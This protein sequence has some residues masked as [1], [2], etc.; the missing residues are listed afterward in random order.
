MGRRKYSRTTIPTEF[1]SCTKEENR[2]QYMSEYRLLWYHFKKGDL[3][4]YMD[5]IKTGKKKRPIHHDRTNTNADKPTPPSVQQWL[6][7]L[8]EKKRRKVV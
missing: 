1:I 2:D 7:W 4:Q 3:E 8:N 6:D 5:D